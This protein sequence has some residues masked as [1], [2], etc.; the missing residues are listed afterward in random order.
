[1]PI[2]RSPRPMTMF[3]VLPNRIIED[4]RL[5]WKARGLL[6]YLLSRPDNWECHTA[7]LAKIAPDGIHTVRSMLSELEDARYMVRRRFQDRH[8]HWRIMTTV[9]DTPYV[10]DPVDMLGDNTIPHADFPHQEN[11]HVYKELTPNKD[12]KTSLEVTTRE[13]PLVCAH[14]SGTGWYPNQA[15]HLEHCGECDGV[16]LIDWWERT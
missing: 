2:R 9:Y 15:D 14:C 11:P 6:I 5:S 12:V 8:G 16:G 10:E 4:R 1:M 3:T 13:T 7:H